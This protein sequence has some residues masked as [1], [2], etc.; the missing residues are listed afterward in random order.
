MNYRDDPA[1]TLL[2][3]ERLQIKDHQGVEY[4]FTDYR[5][6]KESEMIKLSTDHLNLTMLCPLPFLSDYHDTYVTP[7][8]MTHVRLLVDA[9]KP[10]MSKGAL[11]GIDAVKA[12]ILKGI[13]LFSGVNYQAF[14]TEQEAL[15][16]LTGK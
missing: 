16:F 7:D 14:E 6:L 3:S 15:L 4:I 1:I 5:K 2:L 9:A 12:T 11:L 10:I 8:Y 13:V